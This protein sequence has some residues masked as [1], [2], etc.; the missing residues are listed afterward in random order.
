MADDAD[1]LD[2]AAGW[3]RLFNGRLAPD[4]RVEMP[5]L[6]GSMSPLL[7]VGSTLVIAGASGDA[8]RTGDV[9]VYR[10]GERLVAHRLLLGWPPGRARIFL[11]AGDGV[12][13]V[14]WIATAA[15]LGLVI[16]VRLV[17]QTTRD[18][19]QPVAQLE[20]RRLARRRLRNLIW[21]PWR[22][23]LER[24]RAWLRRR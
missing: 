9:V 1:R 3:W 15:I 19:R 7:P 8:C 11:Q 16:A 6:T 18:L 13:P 23:P 14:A 12:S 20:G 24:G 4:Q 2:A 5:M 17:D 22:G 10:D 21:A